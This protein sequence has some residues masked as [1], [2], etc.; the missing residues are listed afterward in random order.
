[1]CSKDEQR[2]A[3]AKAIEIGVVS[4]LRD[5][6]YLID[7]GDSK[8][9]GFVPHIQKL[10]VKSVPVRRRMLDGSWGR[11]SS[12]VENADIYPLS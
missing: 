8:Y 10:A 11:K 4:F 3:D 5:S 12:E 9:S 6:G 2:D 1:M 7:L